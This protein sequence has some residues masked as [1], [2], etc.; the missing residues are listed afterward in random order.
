MGVR[1]LIS[2][3][4]P[5]CRSNNSTSIKTFQLAAIGPSDLIPGRHPSRQDSILA[6]TSGLPVIQEE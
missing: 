1:G 2:R 5:Q 6:L 3:K 4:S